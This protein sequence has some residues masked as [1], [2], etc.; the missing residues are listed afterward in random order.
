MTNNLTPL[1]AAALG[2]LLGGTAHASL[3]DAVIVA[4]EPVIVDE[5]M[6]P[7]TMP[8]ELPV[9]HVAIGMPALNPSDYHV[10]FAMLDHNGDGKVTRGEVRAKWNNGKAYQNL[11][12]EF[13]ATDPNHNGLLT[14]AELGDW[15]TTDD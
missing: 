5:A 10:D 6:T 11:W 8:T 7:E 2:T 1:L 15:L 9:D 13:N 3:Q 14:R 4:P 12:R